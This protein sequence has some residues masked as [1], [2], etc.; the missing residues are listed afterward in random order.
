MTDTGKVDRESF[1]EYIASRL[2]SS[3]E[4]IRK[5][6]TY[7]VDFGVVDVGD[8]A[9]VVA[10]DPISIL[11]ALGHERAGRFAVR[12]ALADV[13]VAGVA[14]THLAVS[15]AL[16]ESLNTD[17]FAAVWR[18]VDA[19]CSALDVGIVTGHTGW[20]AEA[21]LP[22]VGSATAFGLTSPDDVIYP[23]GARP[24]D[25]LLVTNG[26]AVEATGLLTTLFPEQ[27]DLEAETLDAAQERLAD[28]GVVRDALAAADAGGVH[29]IHDATEGGLLG[30]LSEMSRSAE[31]RFAVESDDVPVL[32]GVRETC[33]ALSMDA[34]T[35]TT[36]GTLVIAVAPDAV[37]TVVEALEARGTTAGVAGR[38]EDGEG[39]LVDG[40]RLNPP[41]GDA[42]WP[43]YERLLE[44]AS[45]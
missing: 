41:E 16:P 15:F 6:P 31:M 26:P 4:D 36:A 7:G 21:T 17:E 29:A 39:V 1:A 22:W 44:Q 23:D 2:G 18:G 32:P 24:G 43:V 37:D 25:R 34:W 20:Y 42:S 14:P 45:E 11:L 35:A 19:E 5:G 38:V 8:H 13:A 27:V 28:T 10:T 33:E 40:T 12:F 30:A 3:R 9:L